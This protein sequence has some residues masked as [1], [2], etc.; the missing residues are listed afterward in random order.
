MHL[1]L[2]SNTGR[3]AC[4]QTLTGIKDQFMPANAQNST[5][6]ISQLELYYLQG[7]A[8]SGK[9]C[10]FISVMEPA[11]FCVNCKSVQ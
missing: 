4:Y 2:V 9:T 5:E 3:T 8:R 6:F 1:F 7:E 10:M 11:F